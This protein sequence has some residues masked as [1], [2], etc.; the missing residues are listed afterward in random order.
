M[1]GPRSSVVHC[2]KVGFLQPTTLYWSG[3]RGSAATRGPW[4]QQL[5]VSTTTAALDAIVHWDEEAAIEM[6]LRILQLRGSP[7]PLL[8]PAGR[9]GLCA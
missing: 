2:P 6:Q 8:W 7:R 1:A 3:L 5:G 4:L 9:A